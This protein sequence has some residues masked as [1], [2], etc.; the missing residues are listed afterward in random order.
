MRLAD[1]ARS[2][3]AQRATLELWHVAVLRIYTSWLFDAIN[4]PM[5]DSA[6]RNGFSA[7]HPLAAT[8]LLIAEALKMLRSNYA[9]AECPKEIFWRGMRDMTVDDKFLL[10]GGTEFG[11][12]STSES[13]EIIGMY[14]LSKKTIDSA[15]SLKKLH[16]TRCKH[17]FS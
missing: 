7:P 13:K 11:C 8:L 12:L 3:P 5:R 9:D 14:S 16:D 4:K 10:E 15:I 2:E 6:N 1:F 17:W